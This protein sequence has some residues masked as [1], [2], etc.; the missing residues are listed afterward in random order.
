MK[1]KLTEGKIS[2][3]LLKL[4]LP[5]VWGILALLG[6][7]IIDTYFVAQ[8]GTKELAAISFTF[9][10]ITFL[11]SV[12]IGLGIGVSSCI[13]RAIGKRVQTPVLDRDD[14]K[15]KRLTTDS[16][17]LSLLV[18]AIL[19]ILGLATIEPLF[20]ALGAKAETLPLI[21]QYMKT[22]YLGVIFAVVPIVGNSIIRATGNT[23][24]PSVVMTVAGIVN[25]VLD[26]ILIF[27]VGPISGMGLQGAALATVI[28][29]V[30]TLA[31]SLFFLHYHQQMICWKL[32]S[33][34]LLLR[35]WQNILSI[36]IPNIGQN[37]IIPISVS[38]ITSLIATYGTAAVAAFG[39]ASKIEV[40]CFIVFLALSSS[41]IP[42]VG[43]NWG[44]KQYN[45]V[46][47]GGNLGFK[48]S[49]FWGAII[50]IALAIGGSWLVS[51]FDS[52]PEVI[53]VATK[54]LLIMPISYGTLGI[55][56]ISSATF[57]ALGKPLPSIMMS[58]I[59]V[60]FLYVPLTYL[61]SW[62]LGINGI[63][64]GTCF[65]NLV[66]GIGAYFYFNKTFKFNN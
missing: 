65:A 13:S 58:L 45:R 18:G 20:T 23:F 51:I 32:P 10:V 40:F 26:P 66:V 5:T 17:I 24:V 30:A 44:A 35:N 31:A 50:A 52:D 56:L 59:R 16:L 12:S 37:I 48:F 55:T 6:F 46:Y 60:L 1:Q 41:F 29:M 62:L 7:S 63:F 43:Q 9:P 34:K 53:E 38:F 22:S 49:L 42:F 14:Y 15:V 25:L 3:L 61:G 4:T 47:L 19:V 64:Y 57:N 27:G 11:N 33:F 39:I 36:A 54:Y 8:L 2:T 21:R 28:S